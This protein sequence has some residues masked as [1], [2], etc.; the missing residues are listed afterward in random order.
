M[1]YKKP[2][3][4]V[5]IQF[6]TFTVIIMAILFHS[7]VV[8]LNS[9]PLR[10][11]PRCFIPFRSILYITPLHSIPSPLYS[12]LLH[13]VTYHSAPFY[14]IPSQ[15]S[16]IPYDSIPFQSTPFYSIPSRLY[17]I[18]LHSTSLHSILLRI[19]P[20]TQ[21]HSSPLYSIAHLSNVFHSVPFRSIPCRCAPFCSAPIYSTPFH[22]NLSCSI[23][24]HCSIDFIPLAFY[25]ALFNS[26][27][28]LKKWEKI[29]CQLFL[30]PKT[31]ITQLNNKRTEKIRPVRVHI[32]Y[33]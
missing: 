4:R 2:T 20:L 21:F 12:T 17:S 13:S 1:F 25:S 28:F 18:W 9:I 8:L 14:S 30:I 7:V 5:T 29:S 23:L 22:S 11:I 19:T 6:C 31:S 10:S 33:I 24:F 3:W 27:S 15:L 32:L 16:S 26:S